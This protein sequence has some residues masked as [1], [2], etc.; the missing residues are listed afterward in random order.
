[1]RLNGWQKYLTRMQFDSLEQGILRKRYQRFLAD[2]ELA[3][4]ELIT[5]HCPNTGAMTGC[6]EPGSRVWLSRSESK[7]RKYPHTWELV[8]TSMG[9]ACIRSV[10]ANKV[11][12]EAF[13]A[14]QVSEFKAYPS[15]RAEVKYGQGSRADFLLEGEPGRVFVEVKSVT[16]HR[17]GS[18]GAFPDAVSARGRKHLQALQAVV[19]TNTRAVM[20]FCVFH[21]GIDSVCV[22]GDIDPAYRQALLEAQAGGVEI[23]AWKSDVSPVGIVLSHP[24]PFSVD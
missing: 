2:I 10:A 24:V 1:L 21:M 12:G 16:L 8:Q 6:A 20:L 17:N 19:D 5:V 3:S 15:V 23:M 9:M 7:T 13:E 14:G 4:G 11:V 18:V 22:A